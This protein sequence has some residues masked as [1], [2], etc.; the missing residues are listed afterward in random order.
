MEQT[1][2]LWNG[3]RIP[4]IGLGVFRAS[5]GTETYK[6][7][8]SALAAGYRHIDTARV[9][10]NE[11][12]VGK[13]VLE[14]GIPRK[15]VFVTTK[16]WNDDQG[17]DSTVRAYDRALK[18]S[19]LDYYDLFL[20]HWP[21]PGK[22]LESWKA[23]EA[24]YQHGRVKAIGVSN[25]L[26]RHLWELLEKAT[27]KPMVNQLEVTPFLQQ[28][29]TRRL[30]DDNQIVVEAYSPLTKGVRLAHPTLVAVAQELGRTPAQVLIR[31]GLQN[32]LVV[33][34]KSTQ[35]PR[36]RENHEVWDFSI[37]EG[38]MDQLNRLEEGLVTGWDPRSVP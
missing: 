12:D 15:E 27:V 23:L 2:H 16:L 34:P 7:V 32:N 19:G 10:G 30:C 18:I 8:L 17:Y 35:G 26:K 13:A 20:L 28:R 33:L 4:R 21:V 25:F 22:R 3:V 9:Y 14:S 5:Q 36:I 1:Q 37:P 31:W 24:L 29:E 6:A 38:L 11:A